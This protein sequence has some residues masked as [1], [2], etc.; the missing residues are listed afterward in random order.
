MGGGVGGVVAVRVH[1]IGAE[2][3]IFLA[4]FLKLLQDKDFEFLKFLVG[5]TGFIRHCLSCIMK[6]LNVFTY[7]PGRLSVKRM[8]YAKCSG[9][10]GSVAIISDAGDAFGGSPASDCLAIPPGELGKGVMKP[11][12]F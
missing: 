2:K 6:Q 5:V 9:K 1:D 4:G 3:V 11:F 12:R 8:M 10:P 7:R